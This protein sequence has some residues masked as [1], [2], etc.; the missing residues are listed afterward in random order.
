MD[1][2]ALNYHVNMSMLTCSYFPTGSHT[3]VAALSRTASGQAETARGVQ[4]LALVVVSEASDSRIH[5]WTVRGSSPRVPIPHC[6][7]LRPGL[8]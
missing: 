5:W 8:I 3:F 6:S 4:Y 1:W 2:I 7:L